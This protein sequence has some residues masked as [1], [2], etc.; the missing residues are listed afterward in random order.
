MGRSPIYMLLDATATKLNGYMEVIVV[1]DRRQRI[2]E[3]RNIQKIKAHEKAALAA[4]V[5]NTFMKKDRQKKR[6]P[7]E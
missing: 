4:R 7:K 1:C 3:S 5:S 2:N 6:Y